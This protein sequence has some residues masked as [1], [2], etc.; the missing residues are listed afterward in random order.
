[1]VLHEATVICGTGERYS[2]KGRAAA[3]VKMLCERQEEINRV[4]VGNVEIHFA[5][6][7]GQLY[8]RALL[9]SCELPPHG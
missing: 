7:K 8:V 6:H 5:H 2:A 4:A 1:M 3:M 9:G